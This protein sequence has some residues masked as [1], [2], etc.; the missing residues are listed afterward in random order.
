M[1]PKTG[2]Q[3]ALGCGLLLVLGSCLASAFFGFHVFLDPRG[4]ISDD[5]AAPGMVGGVL[6]FLFSAVVAGVGAF[7]AFRQG[8]AAG[9]GSPAPGAPG[10]GAG[11]APAAALGCAGLFTLLLSCVAT[12]GIPYFNSE[13][14]RWERMRSE[15]ISSG[16][17]PLIIMIDDGAIREREQNM[18][19]SAGS[20]ACCGVT[21]LA[22]FAVAGVLF[23]RARKPA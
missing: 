3:I 11:Q 8:A 10:G 16:A 12:G 22:L 15:D 23:A 14:E 9:D 21:T 7:L 17:D 6:C 5:E 19:A 2:G 20:A 13:M 1:N 18:Y 4:A